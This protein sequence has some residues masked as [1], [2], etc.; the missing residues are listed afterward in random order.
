MKF[1]RFPKEEKTK[2]VDWRIDSIG[3][4]IDIET[5]SKLTKDGIFFI[6]GFSTSLE[7]IK[8]LIDNN[9][10]FLNIDK[11]YFRNRK[12]NSHWRISYNSFQQTKLLTVPDDRLKNNFNIELK[13]WKTSGSYIIV[14]AP[15]PKPLEFYAGTSDV[16][17]WAMSIK[18]QLLNY[19]DKKIFIRFKNMTTKRNDPLIKY[20]DDCYAVVTLQSLGCI[21]CLIEGIPV[22]N[23]AESCVDSLYKQQLENIENLVYPNNRHEWLKSLSYGQYTEEEMQSGYALQTIRKLYNIHENI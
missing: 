22:I 21:E 10:P 18:N 15:N 20:L 12:S 8:L 16:F 19:T 1:Y 5:T 11:G 3:Q 17:S 2:V 13:P 7:K 23:L 6:G 14:L 9:I 4:S